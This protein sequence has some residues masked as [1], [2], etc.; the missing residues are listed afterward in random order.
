MAR[1]LGK[2]PKREESRKRRAAEGEE[3]REHCEEEK[4]E[5]EGESGWRLE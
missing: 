1:V 5:T 4:R 3:N 2:E